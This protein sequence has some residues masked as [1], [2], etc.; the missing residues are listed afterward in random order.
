[1]LSVHIKMTGTTEALLKFKALD[2]GLH[3]YSNDVYASQGAVLGVRW[4]ALSSATT[5]YK[6]KNYSQYAT[7]PLIR[8]GLMKQS[9][10]YKASPVGVV[11][12]ND[13]PYFKYH[14]ST[15]PRSKIPYR[16]T[17]AINE[18]VKLI[19]KTIIEADIKA[20]MEL[21]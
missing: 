4:P 6:A 3:D 10:K 1:M 14:Q 15:E 21:A 7:T 9:Y 12:S 5:K 19:I 8:T 2:L 17:M 11:I 13:A 16:P 20:K 18:P